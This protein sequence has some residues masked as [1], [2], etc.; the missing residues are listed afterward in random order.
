MVKRIT[1]TRMELARLKKRLST[2]SRGHKLLK[3]KQDEMARQFM[4]YIKKNVELR[5][6]VE[7]KISKAMKDVE[8][9]SAKMGRKELGEALM[10]PVNGAK[11]ETGSKNIMSVNVPT[12][13]IKSKKENLNLSYSLLSST[14]QLDSAVMSFADLLPELLEL[15]QIEKTCDM[16]SNEMEK[17]RRRVNALE[18]V[19]IPQMKKNIK[20]ISM[21]LDDN[22][23]S[24]ITRLMKVKEMVIEGQF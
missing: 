20:Y 16:L 1:P 19:M 2:A 6:K 8:I 4:L 23:R 13:K 7:E 24:T 18:H 14:A 5:K 15:A 10:V 11:I 17:T 22:D 12:L 3:D 21:K 9:V